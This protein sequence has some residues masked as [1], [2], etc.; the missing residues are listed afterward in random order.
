MA[1]GG[2]TTTDTRMALQHGLFLLSQHHMHATPDHVEGALRVFFPVQA[3]D[4]L[5]AIRRG[6]EILVKRGARDALGE[7]AVGE[8]AVLGARPLRLRHRDG[9]GDL[10]VE[11]A[12]TVDGARAVGGAAGASTPC[13]SWMRRPSIW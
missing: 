2:I 13:G 4:Y 11:Q 1:N 10:E 6:E 9:L 5:G 12:E 8:A 3:D 7:L